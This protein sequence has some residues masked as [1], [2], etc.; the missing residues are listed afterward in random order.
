MNRRSFLKGTA[1]SLAVFAATGVAAVAAE[2]ARAVQRSSP[3]PWFAP[4]TPR[5][6][7]ISEL[8]AAGLSN[9]EIARCL[10]ITSHTADMQVASILERLNVRGRR[11]ISQWVLRSRRS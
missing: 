3:T 8:V 10:G 9:V 1:A 11:D 6:A 5:L 4:L 2:N 7:Q